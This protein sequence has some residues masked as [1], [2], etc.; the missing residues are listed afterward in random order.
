MGL[1]IKVA[2]EDCVSYGHPEQAI[3]RQKPLE[4]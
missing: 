3:V 4:V 1:Q 2:L